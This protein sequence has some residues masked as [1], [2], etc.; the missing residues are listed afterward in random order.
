MPCVVFV[1]YVCPGLAF[2]VSFVFAAILGPLVIVKTC[3]KMNI[4]LGFVFLT[5][6][7]KK[8]KQI[9]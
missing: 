2:D 4:D 9:V 7:C 6:F 3:L 8:T 5:R 1:A